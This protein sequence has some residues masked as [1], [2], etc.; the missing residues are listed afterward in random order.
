MWMWP[1]WVPFDVAPHVGRRDRA[2]VWFSISAATS[3]DSG[4]LDFLKAAASPSP[5]PKEARPPT[6]P[7][8]ATRS[9]KRGSWTAWKEARLQNALRA[10]LVRWPT[11]V[12][13]T[14]D[15][16]ISEQGDALVPAN[17]QEVAHVAQGERGEGGGGAE[18]RGL[19]G[20]EIRSS[21][22]IERVKEHVEAYLDMWDEHPYVTRY[23]RLAK[24]GGRGGRVEVVEGWVERSERGGWWGPSRGSRRE[25]RGEGRGA[26]VCA[27]VYV[28]PGTSNSSVATGLSLSDPRPA[29][30]ALVHAGGSRKR[31]RAEAG[32][33]VVH[34]CWLV[35]QQPPLAGGEGER[36]AVGFS[37]RVSLR[38]EGGG[39]GVGGEA[40]EGWVWAG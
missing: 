36:I 20:E 32:R 18:W 40:G 10:V 22:L 38:S 33:V 19:S 9:R 25:G 39:Q 11:P 16:V 4:M 3:S 21:R 31:W 12:Y 13:S 26:E 6:V 35:Q 27:L 15:A 5:P 34:P 29:H 30:A 1:S 2:F 17:V 8:V 7:V 28:A 37:F 23:S 14:V 24:E